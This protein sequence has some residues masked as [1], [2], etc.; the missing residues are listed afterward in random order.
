MKIYAMSDIH[1]YIDELIK[2]MKYVDLSGDNKIV[3]LGDY[4]DYGDKSCQVLE[5]IYE[6]NKKYGDDKVIILKGNHEAMLLDW[7]KEYSK[8]VSPDEEILYFDSFLKSDAEDN[9]R[10]FKTFL[11][12]EAFTDYIEK[13]SKR[14]FFELNYEAVRLLL[15]EKRDIIGFI[16]K[17]KPY[18]E[19]ETQI[20]IHAGIDEEAVSDISLIDAWKYSEERSFYFKYP[21]TT[22]KFFKTIIAGHVGTATISGDHNFHDVFYDGKSHYYIDGSVYKGGKI[23]L[24]MFDSDDKRYYQIEDDKKRI[25]SKGLL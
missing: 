17:M 6:L 3:F 12:D 15:A 4:I 18:Y 7:M 13:E 20:F 24:L 2:N 23:P 25:V 16:K 8:K 1:G 10:M 22:G 19:T 9:Y 14:S 21:A 5:Y 11:S